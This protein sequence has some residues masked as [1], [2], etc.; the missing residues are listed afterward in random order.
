METPEHTTA[1]KHND[2]SITEAV[3]NVVEAG[4]R[5]VV[6]RIDV[7]RWD[8]LRTVSRLQQELLLWLAVAMFFAT[9]WIGFNGTAAVFLARQFSWMVAGSAIAGVNAVIGLALVGWSAKRKPAV[10]YDETSREGE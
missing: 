6:D 8:A 7:L 4:Q 3:L 5:V 9:A 1:E 2:S 10:L